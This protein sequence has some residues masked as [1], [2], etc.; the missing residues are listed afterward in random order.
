MGTDLHHLCCA[1]TNLASLLNVA[2]NHALF[3]CP[4]STLAPCGREGEAL[5][6]ERYCAS[7]QKTHACQFASC[8]RCASPAPTSAEALSRPDSASSCRPAA[9]AGAAMSGAR[10]IA[11]RTPVD[12]AAARPDTGA[13]HPVMLRQPVETEAQQHL[14]AASRQPEPLLGCLE[15]DLLAA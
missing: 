6:T 7:A 10:P 3:R 15:P 11:F 1:A 2:A 13:A 5:Q 12:K 4:R 14:A 9:S 8:T